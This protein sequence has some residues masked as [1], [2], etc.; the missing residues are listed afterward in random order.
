MQITIGEKRSG[1]TKLIKRSATERIH[2]LTTTRSQAYKIAKQAREM[3]LNIPYPVTIEEYF[4]HKFRG[5]DIDRKGMLIDDV[6]LVLQ[7]IFTDI[8]IHEVTLPD[9]GNIASIFIPKKPDKS[10]KIGHIYTAEELYE[11]MLTRS[12]MNIR[13]RPPVTNSP[14]TEED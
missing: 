7:H 5:T 8:L 6:D 13:K 4:K 11:A 3:G 14:E 1:T 9:R 12:R 2:I 10:V